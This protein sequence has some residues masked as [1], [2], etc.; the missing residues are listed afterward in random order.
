MGATVNFDVLEERFNLLKQVNTDMGFHMDYLA[1]QARSVGDGTII[2]LGTRYGASTIAFL[3]GLY[4]R[5]EVFEQGELWSVDCSF[6][7]EDTETHIELLN[8]QGPLGC[9]DYWV[10]LLGYDTNPMI[11]EALP[12]EADIVF[13]DTNH[14][15][16]E[17]KV[18]LDLY[19][20]RV[21]PGGKIILHDTS[22]AVTGN[23]D[24]PQP[25]YPVRAA[26]E[27]YC[28]EHGLKRSYVDESYG[29]GTIYVD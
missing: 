20:P 16:E 11:L 18:E 13:I 4:Q 12:N 19:Y 6:P 27:E 15:Y 21:R 17:T 3:Y 23:A 2:E 26:V 8:S 22:L 9:V 25:P 28:N 24:S 29:L 7:V 1:E 14:V 10:F 5:S